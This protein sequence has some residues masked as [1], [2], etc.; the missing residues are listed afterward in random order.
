M[1]E[2]ISIENVCETA[3]GEFVLFELDLENY[4][5]NYTGIEEG[6]E[7][8]CIVICDNLGYC[9]TTF[10][11]VTVEEIPDLKPNAVDDAGTTEENISLTID[12]LANDEINGLIDTVYLQPLPDRGDAFVNN[13]GT[14]TFVPETDYCNSGNPTEFGYVLCNENGCDSAMVRITVHCEAVR[15]H[16]GFS[17]NNDG[18]ND[19][20]VIS[21]IEDL[22]GNR[23]FVYNRW[24]LLV[25]QATDYQNDWQGTWQGT[26]LTDGSYFYL[27]DDGNGNLQS[28]YV[29]IRR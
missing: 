18:K 5:I 13:D 27:F 24:G 23:L 19:S 25:F 28:G 16:N 12:V 11:S 15:V 1:G 26:E 29:Q 7:N 17:P 20:F 14:V 9:D 8:A 6:G 2:V 4:C 3:S 22:P 10:I 21:G